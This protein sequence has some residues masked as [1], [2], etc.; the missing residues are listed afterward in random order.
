MFGYVKPCRPQLRVCELQAYK[1][2]YC[3]LCVQLGRAFGVT[4]R[5][6]LSYDAT[7]L[8]LVGMAVSGEEPDIRPGRCPFNPLRKEPICQPNPSL[9]FSADAAALLLYHKLRDDLSDKGFWGRMG[10]RTALFVFRRVWRDAAGRQP[11]LARIFEEQMERQRGLE[12]ARTP[13]ADQAADPTARMLAAV[14]PLLDP[15]QSRVL[16]RLG[17]LVGRYIYLADALD[18]LEAD[19]DSGGYNPFLLREGSL[20]EQK[21]AGLR[22]LY[23]T[24]GEAG[25]TFQLLEVRRFG[26]ILENILTLGIHETADSLLLPPKARKAREK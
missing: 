14:L 17:Y 6:T 21:Q 4:A 26:P 22:S 10:A 5:F 7:F 3:G 24:I 23:L 1:A 9:S 19:R 13:D 2:V 11:E 18:D 12:Q 20:E 8:A 16:E 15:D 25:T